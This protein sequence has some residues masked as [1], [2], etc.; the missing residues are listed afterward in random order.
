MTDP[1]P[2]DR[3]I[4]N[5]KERI[6]EAKVNGDAAKFPAGFEYYTEYYTGRTDAYR[7]VLRTVYGMEE[8]EINEVANG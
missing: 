6:R 1:M 8:E 4:K 3:A 5:I 7:D 2:R